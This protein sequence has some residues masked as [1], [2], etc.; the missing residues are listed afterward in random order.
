MMISLRSV[1]KTA[2]SASFWQN[3]LLDGK[4]RLA[5]ISNKKPAEI[6][7]LIDRRWPNYSIWVPLNSISIYVRNKDLASI[8]GEKKVRKPNIPSMF[9]SGEWDLHTVEIDSH[10]LQ[11]SQSYRSVFQILR[12]GYHYTMCDEYKAKLRAIKN[13]KST[14]RG[15]SV[16]ELN[17]YFENL[18]K[19]AESVKKNGYQSQAILN[20][21]PN[22]EIGIFIGRNGEMIKPEDKFSG[23]HRFAI[24]KCLGIEKVCVR[25]L[26]VHDEWANDN[27]HLLT[28]PSRK[29]ENHFN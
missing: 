12:E 14:A 13:N 5:G 18:L 27:L 6:Q 7:A 20:G 19:I 11:E 1:V 17:S 24:A 22:D 9:W 8:F 23:T 3:L 28:R 15:S 4:I 16:A 2:L 29:L 21:D 25:I 26:A 10:Y